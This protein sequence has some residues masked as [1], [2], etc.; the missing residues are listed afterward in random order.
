[1]SNK[2]HDNLRI[3]ALNLKSKEEKNSKSEESTL[4]IEFII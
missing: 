3:I 1:M 2:I 4:I